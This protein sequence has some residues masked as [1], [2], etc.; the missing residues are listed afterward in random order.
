MFGAAAASFHVSPL[1]SHLTRT[2]TANFLNP[3]MSECEWC[4]TLSLVGLLAKFNLFL[5]SPLPCRTCVLNNMIICCST[6]VCPSTHMPNFPVRT[7]WTRSP[8][9]QVRGNSN[10]IKST[11]RIPRPSIKHLTSILT[12]FQQ[13][14]TNTS[15]YQTANDERRDTVGYRKS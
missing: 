6:K 12:K 9:T 2:C 1:G 10:G 5:Q 14:S 8:P 15:F 13:P 4:Q 7:K 3:Q 11:S